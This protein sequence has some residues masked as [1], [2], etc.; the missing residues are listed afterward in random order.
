[1]YYDVI[2]E[3]MDL[4]TIAGKVRGRLYES[5]RQ[6]LADV[7]LIFANCAA[8]NEEDCP[9]SQVNYNSPVCPPVD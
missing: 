5:P 6:L 1:M 2:R 4:R 7:A 3:P 9:V 8:F